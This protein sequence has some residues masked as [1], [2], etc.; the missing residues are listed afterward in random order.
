MSKIN[1]KTLALV[2]DSPSSSSLNIGDLC[3]R[4]VVYLKNLPSAIIKNKSTMGK[5]AFLVVAV[6]L[7][8]WELGWIF[9]KKEAKA[10]LDHDLSTKP[11]KLSHPLSPSHKVAP[12]LKDLEIPKKTSLP[13]SSTV[14]SISE[15]L[16]INEKTPLLS[17]PLNSSE[18][19]QLILENSEILPEHKTNEFFHKCLL[20]NSLTLDQLPLFANLTLVDFTPLNMH[21]SLSKE[22]IEG[23]LKHCT[24]IKSIKIC[25][26]QKE[27]YFP[28]DGL[29][30]IEGF[31][32]NQFQMLSFLLDQPEKIKNLI[33][34]P[35]LIN[36]NFLCYFQKEK[37][38]FLFQKLQQVKHPSL[39]SFIDS[40]LEGLKDPLS[41][42]YEYATVN[43]L[44]IMKC[45][46]DEQV[47]YC[48]EEL[49]EDASSKELSAP[50]EKTYDK[51]M[52][53]LN[54][55]SIDRFEKIISDIIESQDIGS[56]G[57]E[58]AI[59]L[60]ASLDDIYFPG[61]YQDH[62]ISNLYS[63]IA[64]KLVLKHDSTEIPELYSMI[65]I[66]AKFFMQFMTDFM[67]AILKEGNEKKILATFKEFWKGFSDL[68]IDD[69][70]DDLVASSCLPEL[71]ASID[72]K[73]KYQSIFEALSNQNIEKEV[74]K[75]IFYILIDGIKG[76]EQYFEVNMSPLEKL[77][78]N[79]NLINLLDEYA[80]DTFCDLELKV[81][82]LHL[83][84]V[85]ECPN[86]P[87]L[88]ADLANAL[89]SEVLLLAGGG[90]PMLLKKFLNLT[91]L[92][93]SAFDI[94]D[95]KSIIYCGKQITKI[96][97]DNDDGDIE[98]ENV[99]FLTSLIKNCGL[100]GNLLFSIFNYEKKDFSKLI[101]E[102]ATQE[103]IDCLNEKIKK[104]ALSIKDEKVK[105]LSQKLNVEIKGI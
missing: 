30:P 24:Q 77:S 94:E 16:E 35:E 31:F 39:F 64:L 43:L 6:S 105:A 7:I 61:G 20:E 63:N 76:E 44:E 93:I 82:Y 79:C 25:P 23:M 97:F 78:V 72:N 46:T 1:S 84:N 95:I 104:K 11:L 68:E 28:H 102:H 87:P 22:F 83:K 81:F 101:I 86:S 37:A 5:I 96:T 52:A 58:K 66:N 53:L 8:L 51:N 12:I 40:L 27:F 32:T 57:F 41:P 100:N 48:F 26:D 75:Q 14:A 38:V 17:T 18:P 50:N 99:A 10:N 29:K 34:F 45:L 55:L 9:A 49:W 65:E 73:Q 60:L 59:S 103:Q 33:E 54:Y 47:I 70:N 92:H 67:K 13:S 4:L 80:Y 69:L 2:V 98:S 21:F 90:Q 91:H 15:N 71:L 42:E 74:L 62:K 89:F 85:L 3:G 36:K 88:D 19:S 56:G